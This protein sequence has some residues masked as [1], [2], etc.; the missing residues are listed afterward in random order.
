MLGLA[1]T[2]YGMLLAF[3]T[4][5]NLSLGENRMATLATGIYA[6]LIC[7]FAGLVVAIP[8][9][10]LAHVFEGRIMKLFR[11]IDDLM[12]VLMPQMERYEG[13]LPAAKTHA[14]E[15]GRRRTRVGPLAAEARR[16]RL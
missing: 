4:T 16:N 13:R 8:A 15:L 7:T 6:A 10:I 12:L 3:F 9:G 1:G 11:E 14:A 2:V 5:A